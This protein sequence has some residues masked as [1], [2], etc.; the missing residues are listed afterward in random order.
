MSTQEL[1][2]ALSDSPSAHVAA[3]LQRPGVDPNA[4]RA[5]TTPLMF[6][7][8]KGREDCV[9]PLL[10]AGAEVNAANAFGWTPLM[11][12]TR[13]G[14]PGIVRLLLAAGAD[15]AWAAPTG[16]SA[17][18]VASRSIQNERPGAA[19]CVALLASHG[20]SLT[21]TNRAR[22]TPLDAAIA[23]GNQVVADAISALVGPQALSRSPAQEA[24]QETQAAAPEAREEA[25][26]RFG[27]SKPRRR[28]V[29]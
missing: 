28:G 5:D 22:Q 27:L 24:A 9:A 23:R 14:H 2:A 20:A 15:A 12:A 6:A 10:A 16:D 29:G 3:L 25:P 11:E 7:V 17:A 1:F 8:R 21:R 19:E 4:D 26:S 13:S 18:H